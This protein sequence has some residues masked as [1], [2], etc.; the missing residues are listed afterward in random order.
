M[1]DYGR[2]SPLVPH[3]FRGLP[4]LEPHLSKVTLPTLVL[5]GQADRTLPSR[6]G[7]V[8]AA[9][10]AGLGLEIAGQGHLPHVGTPAAVHTAMISFLKTLP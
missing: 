9:L 4:A 1:A 3:L 10:P 5:W 6:L 7:L 2:T 8:L